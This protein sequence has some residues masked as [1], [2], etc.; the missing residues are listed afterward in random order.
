MHLVLDL[1]GT[2]IEEQSE[3]VEG[4]DASESDDND[5]IIRLIPHVHEFL[6]FCFERFQTISIWSAA[7]EDH[8]NYY[9]SILLPKGREWLF[10]KTG[11]HCRKVYSSGFGGSFSGLIVEKR[12]SNVWKTSRF[13]TAGLT[14]FNTIIVDDTPMVCSKNYGNAIY[15]KT[16]RGDKKDDEL[17]KLQRYLT[18][19]P[20]DVNVRS[21][22]KRNW[23]ENLSVV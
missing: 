15:V 11:K 17:L 8:V 13:K 5:D 9:A 16:F 2:L 22:E 20:A 21:T 14:R 23:R 18:A 7:S 3:Y 6:H 1:D 12:L 4:E 10:I 19:L